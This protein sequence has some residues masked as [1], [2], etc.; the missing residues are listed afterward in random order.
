MGKSDCR[1]KKNSNNGGKIMKTY[2]EKYWKHAVGIILFFSLLY[3]VVYLATPKP[4][5]SELDKYKIDQI[6]KKIEDL[7]NLLK[8]LND[9]LNVYQQKIDKIDDK[10][11]N[12]K[13]EKKEVNNYYTQK[14]EE[15]KK[16]D[17]KQIDSL[18]RKRY[19]Y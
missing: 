13:I 7:K 10:I 5:M 9:S 3:L 6:I 19:N 1:K 15:I 8:S 17:N 14:K 16:A 4:K 18:L 2:V 12:I 11:S